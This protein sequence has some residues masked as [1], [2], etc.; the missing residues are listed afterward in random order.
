VRA[1]FV[2]IAQER[3]SAKY[4]SRF[5]KGNTILIGD[6]LRDVQVSRNGGA[7]VIAVATGSDGMEALQAE[8][9]DIVLPD[10]QDESALLEAVTGFVG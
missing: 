3:A 10:L 2:G 1:N 6:T 5:G 7:R 8:A 9:A 4:G